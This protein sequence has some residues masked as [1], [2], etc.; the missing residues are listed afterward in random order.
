MNE[1]AQNKK[2]VPRA[3]VSVETSCDRLEQYL[4]EME[5]A[6]CPVLR[7]S[8]PSPSPSQPEA[9]TASAEC[10]LAEAI[11]DLGCRVFHAADRVQDI[12][13]RLEL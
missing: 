7:D 2:A 10:T 4:S 12:I 8:V 1:T 11:N 13:S 5:G 3:M 9:K 6:L